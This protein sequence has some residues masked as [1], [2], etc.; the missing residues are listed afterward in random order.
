M[1]SR[2]GSEDLVMFILFI[3]SVLMT[4]GNIRHQCKYS[5]REPGLVVW[6]RRSAC[7]LFVDVR[8][9]REQSGFGAS[10]LI[11]ESQVSERDEER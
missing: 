2:E 9:T 3:L 11:E 5:E 1:G 10:Y 4:H 8:G 7:L 6:G